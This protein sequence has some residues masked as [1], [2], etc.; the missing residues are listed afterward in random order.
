MVHTDSLPPDQAARVQA[1]FPDL[2][3]AS[4]RFVGAGWDHDAWLL[5]RKTLLRVPRHPVEPGYLTREAAFLDLLAEHTTV[6]VPAVS[7]LSE[8]ADWC[9]RL[10]RGDPRRIPAPLRPGLG[11]RSPAPDTAG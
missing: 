6:D 8:D 5:N 3:H 10:A 9:G 11:A 1:A 2:S 7:H 4:A